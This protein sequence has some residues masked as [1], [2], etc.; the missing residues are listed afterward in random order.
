MEEKKMAEKK[1]LV[2]KEVTVSKALREVKKETEV[3]TNQLELEQEPTI[4]KEIPEAAMESQEEEKEVQISSLELL[5]KHALGELD[6]WSNRADYRDEI[7]LKAA[8]DYSKAIKRNRDNIKAISEQ[9]AKEMAEWERTARE[10]ILMS[11]TTIQHFVPVRSYEEINQMFDNLQSKASSILYAPFR[12]VAGNEPTEK[13]IEMI[14]QYIAL[15]KES[16]LQYIRNVKQTA[17][18]IY[19]N[20]KVFVN[21]FSNQIKAVLFPFN[22][23][24]EKTE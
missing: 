19:E 6:E 21:L 10:E 20:Q 11:T 3:K 8:K 1:H 23:Y 4:E 2:K 7:F 22:K 15:R 9:F 24:L 14:E 18:Q 16:R 13:A 12:A 5:W 17:G